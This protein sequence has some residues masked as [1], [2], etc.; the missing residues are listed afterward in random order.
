MVAI[1]TSRGRSKV[2]PVAPAMAPEPERKLKRRETVP[3]S[4]GGPEA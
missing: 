3:A 1:Y 4:D 2:A